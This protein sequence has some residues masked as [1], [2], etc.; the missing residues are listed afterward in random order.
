ME[1]KFKTFAP[2]L[3]VCSCCDPSHNIII[4]KTIDYLPD[5]QEERSAFLSIH[6]E[7]NRSIWKRLKMAFDVLFKK[8]ITNHEAYA[9]ICIT[10]NNIKPLENLVNFIKGKD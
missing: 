9:E 1:S 2:E 6:L 3:L 8:D 7:V 4:N 10:E 5:N